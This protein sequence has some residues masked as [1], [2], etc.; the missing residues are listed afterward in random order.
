ML[1]LDDRTIAL[2]FRTALLEDAA[3]PGER[4]GALPA[5]ISVDEDGDAWITLDEEIWSEEKDP[6]A[7]F[8]LAELPGSELELAVTCMT[9][10]VAWPELGHV[11]TRTREYVQMLLDAYTQHGIVHRKDGSE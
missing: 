11:S 10:P 8:A 3:T 2:V 1:A 4:L 6:D 9:L 5:E 7:A